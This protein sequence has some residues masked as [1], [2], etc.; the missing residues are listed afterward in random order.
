MPG[1]PLNISA[2]LAISVERQVADIIA[3]AKAHCAWSHRA[4]GRRGLRDRTTSALVELHRE[5]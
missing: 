5:R 3:K 1:H 4:A 2:A